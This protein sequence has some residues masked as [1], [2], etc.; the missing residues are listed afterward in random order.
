MNL[1]LSKPISFFNKIYLRNKSN[2]S[3]NNNNSVCFLVGNAE[4]RSTKLI[5]FQRSYIKK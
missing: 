1:R 4:S 5:L 2:N 3:N